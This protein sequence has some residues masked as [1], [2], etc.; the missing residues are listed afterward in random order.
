MQ[1]LPAASFPDGI[2]PWNNNTLVGRGRILQNDPFWLDCASDV[3]SLEEDEAMSFPD[4]DNN[5]NISR[6]HA[7]QHAQHAR[8]QCL[9][10]P[11]AVLGDGHKANVMYRSMKGPRDYHPYESEIERVLRDMDEAEEE[12]EREGEDVLD[13]YYYMD[14][15]KTMDQ[16][17]Y[18]RPILPVPVA[19]PPMSTETY[20]K[21]HRMSLPIQTLMSKRIT[22]GNT[23]R[24]RGRAT[25]V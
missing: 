16:Q 20:T 21:H 7:M 13:E 24:W 14:A 12:S 2:L 9:P 22:L 11:T 3:P 1:E 5:N 4:L 6:A 8:S 10:G 23:F 25:A 18:R 15:Y 17:L 19:P